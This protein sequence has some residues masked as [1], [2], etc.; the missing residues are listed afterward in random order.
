[1]C[2]SCRIENLKAQIAKEDIIVYKLVMKAT[3]ESCMSPFRRY[4]YRKDY[5]QTS[6]PIEIEIEQYSAYAGIVKGYYSY[7]SVSFICDSR[8]INISGILSK[9]IQCGNRIETIAVDN[10]LY[11]A[12]FIIPKDAVYLVNEQ[13][14][15]VSNSIIY[16]GKYLKL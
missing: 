6:L 15:I 4:N 8:K 3:E 2:W 16:T 14:I 5:I 10:S 1:M 12:T 11:L 9:D 7:K 13:G